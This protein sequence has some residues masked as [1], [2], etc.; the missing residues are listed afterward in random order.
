MPPNAPDQ[1]QAES[2]GKKKNLQPRLLDLVVGNYVCVE[3]ELT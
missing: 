3:Q 1:K 2:F